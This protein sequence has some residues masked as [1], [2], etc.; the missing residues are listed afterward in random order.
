MNK[1]HKVALIGAAGRMGKAI[2]Q[3]LAQS[4]SLE[5]SGAVEKSDSIVIGMDSGV[6]SL[7]KENHILYT[8]DLEDALK[9]SDVAID[10]S[11]HLNT[12]EVLGVAKEFQKPVVIG[13][14]GHTEEEK[15]FIQE[16]S[17]LIPILFSPNMSIGVNLLFKLVEISARVLGEHFDIEVLDIHHRHKKD[18]PS[19][20]AMKIKQI[21]LDTLQRKEEDVVYGRHGNHYS[22]RDLKQIG[23][24]TMRAGEVVGEH[25]VYFFSP[26]ERIELKHSAQ[27]R[28]TFAVGAIKAAE[29]LIGQKPGLYTMFDVLGI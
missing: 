23:I 5:L 13:A 11:S 8:S 15:K 16:I 9:N 25:T 2:V 29:F 21:L 27:D 14:T 22:E 10:F 7:L 26:E 19:G 20:T 4:A 12:K 18:A 1:K 17:K 3:V 28:K 6:N 24:H